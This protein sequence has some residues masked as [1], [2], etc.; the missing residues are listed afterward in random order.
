M[1]IQKVVRLVFV[2]E[3]I[4][5]FALQCQQVMTESLTFASDAELTLVFRVNRVPAQ[6]TITWWVPQRQPQE[7]GRQNGAVL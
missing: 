6:G 2:E 1:I 7:A 4:T 5:M 3:L